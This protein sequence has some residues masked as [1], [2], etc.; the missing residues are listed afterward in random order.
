MLPAQ[1]IVPEPQTFQVHETVGS[2]DNG[3][4]NTTNLYLGNLSPKVSAS[5]YFPSKLASLNK[6]TYFFRSLNNN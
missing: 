5:L 4:P 3:D 6:F 2:F 1:D